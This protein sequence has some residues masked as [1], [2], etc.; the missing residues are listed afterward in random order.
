MGCSVQAVC[1]GLLRLQ[2]GITY[3][4]LQGQQVTVVTEVTVGYYLWGVAGTTG[5]SGYRGYSG[6][7]L[8]GG[9]RDNRLQW[10]QRLQWGIT[11]GG[12]QGQQVTVVTE[13]TVG[14][15]L[16]GVAGTTGYSGYRGYSGV[17]LMGGCRDNRLQWLQRL[18]WGI[19]YGGLQGQ[20]GQFQLKFSLNLARSTPHTL[21]LN[22]IESVLGSVLII[23][24]KGDNQLFTR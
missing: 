2:W 3:G 21:F 19:T 24:I 12:L 20:H 7:L 16:W 6:V 15:Y 23:V 4:G 9:C 22:L 1:S 11:Y 8:M 14:Y 18:Q 17:L 13:V 5:Y 10:L